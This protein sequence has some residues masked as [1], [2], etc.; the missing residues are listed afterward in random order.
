MISFLWAEDE[1]GLIGKNND[2]PWRLPADLKYFKETTMGYAII[3]GRK[4]YESIGKPLPG[5][6]NII[7]TRDKNYQ[8]EGCLVFH[9]KDELLQWIIKSNSN[10]FVTGGSEI[11]QLFLDEVDRL[12]V[13]KIF[14]TFEGNTYFPKLD[15]DKWL[16]ISSQK[17][18]KNEKNP[19]N[20]EFRVYK[21]K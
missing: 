6:T 18:Q 15:W 16:I 13:T 5:R 20:Y 9:S 3:M 17:G 4:T 19:Y 2:L 8:V 14:H 11:F 21:R 12:Y 1:N 10:V 7:L